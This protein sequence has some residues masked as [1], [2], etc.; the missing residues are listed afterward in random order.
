MQ[1]RGRVDH[2]PNC[3]GPMDASPLAVTTRV[4]VTTH[5]DL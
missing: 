3:G 1:G 4:S 2:D 5:S